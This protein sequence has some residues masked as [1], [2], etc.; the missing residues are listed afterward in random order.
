M[1][2]HLLPPNATR[3][4]VATSLAAARMTDFDGSV[5][6][7]W[8][9]ADIPARYLPWLAWALSIDDWNPDWSDEVKR[10]AIAASVEIHRHKGTVWA[11]RRALQVAGL[12]DAIIQEG[13]SANH[14]DGFARNGGRTRVQSDHWAEYRV[15]LARAMSI[16]QA[17]QARAILTAAAP[18]RSHLKLMD[19][20]QAAHLYNDTIPRSGTNTRGTV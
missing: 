9:P 1:T 3:A 11:M 13:W 20:A 6:R 19:F 16:P 15:R 17:A 5:E 18:V 10:A 7:M 4:E 2:A 8:S 12:G 14:Y